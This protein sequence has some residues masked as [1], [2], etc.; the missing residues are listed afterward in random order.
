MSQENVDVVRRLFE[1]HAR[2]DEETVREL[3]DPEIQWEDVSG[4]WGDW[5]TRHG[6]DGVREAFASWFKAFEDVTFIAEDFT[7]AGEHVVVV[8]R[9]SGRGRSSGLEVDQHITLLW[10]VRGGRVTSVRGYRDRSDA[11]E[12]VGLSEN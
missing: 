5:G 6:R 10:A 4:L 1:A 12:A 3:Y 7:D 11:L 2:R 8:T 9:I